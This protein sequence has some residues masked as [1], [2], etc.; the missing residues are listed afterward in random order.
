MAKKRNDLDELLFVFLDDLRDLELMGW[1]VEIQN[2]H[3]RN[4]AQNAIENREVAEPLKKAIGLKSCLSITNLVGGEGSRYAYGKKGI[5]DQRMVDLIAE[6][7]AR[8][9]AQCVCM[10]YESFEKYVKSISPTIFYQLRNDYE[11]KDSDGL[12][13]SLDKWSR[14]EHKNTPDYFHAYVDHIARQ[15]VSALTKELREMLPKFAET[16][17]DNWFGDLDAIRRLVDCIRH[18]TVHSLGRP[19]EAGKKYLQNWERESF[20]QITKPSALSGEDTVL[21]TQRVM[22]MVFEGISALGY[23]LYRCASDRC[24]MELWTP[25]SGN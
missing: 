25:S 10:V 15:N 11:L 8:Q 16:C 21:P 9:Q 2:G 17:D 13:R 22:T 24:D 3:L 12:H 6:I 14:V 7:G 5:H 20:D 18:T 1:T 23:S 4:E 19:S